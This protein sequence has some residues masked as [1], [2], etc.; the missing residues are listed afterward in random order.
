M[1]AD[2]PV[3]RKRGGAAGGIVEEPQGYV[4]VSDVDGE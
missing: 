3:F 4:R 1:G 2:A